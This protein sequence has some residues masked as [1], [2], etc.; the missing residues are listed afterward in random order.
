MTEEEIPY[1]EDEES[2]PVPG[3]PTVER[4]TIYAVVYNPGKDEVLCLDWEKF[5]WKSFIIGG[6]EEGEDPVVAAAREITEESGY[7]NLEFVATLGRT[8]SAYYAAHKKENRIANAVGVLFRLTNEEQNPDIKPDTTNHIH[9]WVPRSQ[10][11]SF[12]NLSSQKYVWGKA[13]EKLG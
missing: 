8:R 3:V 1:F 4:E 2:K 13:K 6:V 12:I 10:I 7:M 5:G 9:R 11:D